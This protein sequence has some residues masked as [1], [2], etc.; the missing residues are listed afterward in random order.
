M[1]LFRKEKKSI[2]NEINKEEEIQ[3]DDIS[4]LTKPDNSNIKLKK[5]FNK[6]ILIICGGFLG[7]FILFFIINSSGFRLSTLL[8]KN[9]TLNTV[10]TQHNNIEFPPQTTI[11]VN[12]SESKEKIEQSDDET[13]YQYYVL[14]IPEYFHR[15]LHR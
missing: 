11:S 14:A 12:L 9:K 4:E 8:S 7:I 5:K 13:K 2:N 3:F 1:T 6:N 15:H 10:L